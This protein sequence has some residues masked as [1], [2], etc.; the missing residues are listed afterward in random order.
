MTHARSVRAALVATLV[1]GCVAAVCACGSEAEDGAGTAVPTV[2]AG[3]KRD[4]AD[5][6]DEGDEDDDAGPTA[7]DGG[8]KEAGT[9]GGSDAGSEAGQDAGTCSWPATHARVVISQIYG[10]GG[11]TDSPYKNDFVELYNRSDAPIS[12]AGWS[13]QYASNVGAFPANAPPP[14]DGMM[15]LGGTIPAHGFYLVKA[16]KGLGGAM[17]VPAADATAANALIGETNGKLVLV[18]STTALGAVTNANL[19]D[20]NFRSSKAIEDF[21]GYGT[22]ATFEGAKAVGFLTEELAGRRKDV[23]VDTNDNGADFE[24]VAPAPR[25]ASMSGPACACPK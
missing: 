25:N 10:G 12:L 14:Q 22:A 6:G 7:D 8:V 9:D 24:K 18:R 3:K 11:N 2:D 21:V 17:D 13:V 5:A 16:A 19:A 15:P 1:A 23:C 4:A 20:D